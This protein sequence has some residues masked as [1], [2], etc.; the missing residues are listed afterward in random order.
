ME[1][2]IHIPT[3]QDL[4][5]AEE[6]SQWMADSQTMLP[7]TPAQLHDFFA[8]GRSVIL[9]YQ[10]TT[11]AHAAIS[12]LWPDNWAELGAVVVNPDF[13]GHGLG[14]LVVSALLWLA[15]EQF[16]DQKLFALCNKY[17]LKAFLH[18]GG[19]KITD[20]NLLP[21]EVWGECIHCPMR[22]QAL[23]ENKLCCDIPV[24]MK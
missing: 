5:K 22:G 20:P 8:H 9:A 11:L 2:H 14:H 10:D 18:N 16:P 19:Q 4:A 23:S 12:F 7:K 24:L 1:H 3:H 6:I 21:Q 13:R 15:G 17:S